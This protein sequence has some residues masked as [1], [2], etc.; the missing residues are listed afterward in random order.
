MHARMIRRSLS[1]LWRRISLFTFVALTIKVA[2]LIFSGNAHAD[3]NV[4]VINVEHEDSYASQR[5]YAGRT[6]A[7]RAAQLGFKRGGEV[8]RQRGHWR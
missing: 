1:P 3:I 6:I 8:D 5:I 4:S 7:S 2:V